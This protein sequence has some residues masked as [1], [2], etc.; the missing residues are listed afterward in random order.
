LYYQMVGRGV[1]PF[2]GK[3]ACKLIDLTDNV[4]RFGI[5][6]TFIL[7]DRNGNG[8]WRLKSDVGP[9]TGVDVATGMELES[10]REPPQQQDQGSILVPFGKYKDQPIS[11]VP[12]GYLRWAVETFD[13]A[14]LKAVFKQECERRQQPKVPDSNVA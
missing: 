6:E 14:H 5:I 13:N 7:Y 2:P 12:T 4:R 1:R 11:E 9:L 10:V 3:S 8:M